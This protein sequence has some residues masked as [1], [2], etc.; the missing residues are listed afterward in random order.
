MLTLR[1]MQIK[2]IRKYHHTCH[3]GIIKKNTNVGKDV[4][5]R[6][7]SYTVVRI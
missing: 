1:E 3:M 4:E 7:P 6:E 5:E 2:T